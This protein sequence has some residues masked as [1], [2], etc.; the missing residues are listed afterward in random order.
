MLA[1]DI[2]QRPIRKALFV[3]AD[4]CRS[5]NACQNRRLPRS[6]LRPA[7]DAHARVGNGERAAKGDFRLLLLKD[8]Q[9]RRVI[10]PVERVVRATRA[11]PQAINEKEQYRWLNVAHYYF[12]SSSP[13]AR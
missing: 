3:M 1:N 9:W 12:W 5:I 13:F 10:Q 8:G 2:Q 4:G 11:N 7:F 6:A